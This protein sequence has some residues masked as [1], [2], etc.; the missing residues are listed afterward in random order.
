[1]HRKERGEISNKH[2]EYPPQTNIVTAKKYELFI[3]I[4]G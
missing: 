1:M 3:F 4:H 2:N